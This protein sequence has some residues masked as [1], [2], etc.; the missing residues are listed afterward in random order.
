MSKFQEV[1]LVSN[2]TGAVMSG[3]LVIESSTAYQVAAVGQVH[4][5]LKDEWSG[6]PAATG[7][8]DDLFGS[9]FGGGRR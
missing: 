1:R 3:K 4:T 5:F 8:F 7:G 6:A 9:F 2:I